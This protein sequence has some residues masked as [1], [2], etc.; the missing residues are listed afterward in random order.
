MVFF[1][2]LPQSSA[3]LSGNG[4]KKKEGSRKKEKRKTALDVIMVVFNICRIYSVYFVFVL[5]S[6]SFISVPLLHNFCKLF[7]F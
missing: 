5:F 3:L 4:E 2:A 6:A 7:F 1:R